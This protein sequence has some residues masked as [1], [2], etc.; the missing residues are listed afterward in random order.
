MLY[1]KKKISSFCIVILLHYSKVA[2]IRHC[3]H[4]TKNKNNAF[5]VVFRLK[6]VECHICI[7]IYQYLNMGLLKN[8][9]KNKLNK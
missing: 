9:N 8:I 3:Q 4:I 2:V 5:G 6:R 1:P 7:S